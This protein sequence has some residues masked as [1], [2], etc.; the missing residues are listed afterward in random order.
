MQNV[1]LYCSD[2]STCKDKHLCNY[3]LRYT[4]VHTHRQQPEPWDGLFSDALNKTVSM[5]SNIHI[6]DCVHADT[7]AGEHNNIY[8]LITSLST[9]TRYTRF[10]LLNQSD[11][12]NFSL[13]RVLLTIYSHFVSVHL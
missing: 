11:L 13:I 6:I 9:R 8:K 2:E 7:Y 5:I 3:T 4:F 10:F 1:W 12:F